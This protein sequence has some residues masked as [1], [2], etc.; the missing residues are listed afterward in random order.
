MLVGCQGTGAVAVPGAGQVD[1]TPPTSPTEAN[2]GTVPTGTTQTQTATTGP[3]LTTPTTGAT[4]TTPGVTG[5]APDWTVDC[6]GNGDF[7]TIQDAIDGAQSGQRIGVQ[8][9]T[10]HERIDFDGKVLEIY[11]IQ[12]SAQTILDGDET[13]TVVN[14]ETYEGLGTRI[15][16]M[17]ITG[18]DDDD[19]GSAI[20]VHE[21]YLELEDVVLRDNGESNAVLYL[22]I[23]FVDL[24]NV[25]IYDND[26]LSTGN[27]IWSDSGNLT[28]EDST[29]DCD[30][31]QAGIWHHNNLIL[32]DTEV[33]C[34]GEYGIEDYH[35]EDNIRRSVVYGGSVGIYAHDTESL[36]DMPDNPTERF[37]LWNSNVQGGDVGLDLRYMNGAI[38]NSVLAGS[39]SALFMLQNNVA[40]HGASNVYANAT[41][42]IVGD[43][44]FD[45]LF[46]AFWNNDSDGCGLTVT[47]TVT[48]DPLF[49]AFPLDL[50]L[51]AG[52]PLINAGPP[53]AINNDVD[54]SRNDIGV[55]GGPNPA[56]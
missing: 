22:N 47:P 17:T 8:P 26:I 28:I 3:T 52:S 49:V 32:Q 20:E 9:C 41:C 6:N 19:D 54:G 36:P 55:H 50:N 37:W 30:G 12:G 39:D 56:M 35:G 46:S 21:A 44:A 29:I 11:G 10:Y 42:G 48:S 51:Q 1:D 31:G 5:P 13:G 33:F 38:Y 25:H 27:A 34:A 53:G 7:V 43:Q 16:G 40:T 24:K 15:A 23:A 45:A 14:I 2:T 4:T 18:G